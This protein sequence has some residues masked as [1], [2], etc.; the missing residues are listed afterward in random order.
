M[1]LNPGKP[2]QTCVRWPQ[3]HHPYAEVPPSQTRTQLG[4]PMTVCG[5]S[6]R[7]SLTAPSSKILRARTPFGQQAQPTLMP[8][9]L[10]WTFF[11]SLVQEDHFLPSPESI[12]IYCQ[13]PGRLHPR[14]A[15]CVCAKKGNI[16][17]LLYEVCLLM[18]KITIYNIFVRQLNYQSISFYRRVSHSLHLTRN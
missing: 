7:G 9:R 2:F 1:K 17:I 5:D 13:D 12:R 16:N 8:E 11:S 15:A 18:I 6:L 4:S 3:P 10:P 14:F